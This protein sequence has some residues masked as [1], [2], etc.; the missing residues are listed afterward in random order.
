[1]RGMLSRTVTFAAT[2]LFVTGARAQPSEVGRWQD[3]GPYGG[4]VVAIARSPVMPD[5][6]F[7][8]TDGFAEYGGLFRSTDGGTTWFHAS[9]LEDTPIRAL[10]FTPDGTAFAGTA[11]DSLWRSADGGLEWTVLNLGVSDRVRTV[12]THPVDNSRIWASVGSTAAWLLHSDDGGDTWQDVGIPTNNSFMGCAAIA[13]DAADPD[14]AFAACGSPGQLWFSSDGGLSW[15]ERTAGLPSMT[16][17][18]LAHD[19]TR[20]LVGGTSGLYASSD[21]GLSWVRLSF[22]DARAVGVDPMEPDV[23]YLGSDTPTGLHRSTD[24]GMS[25]QLGVPGTE[26]LTINALELAPGD[27]SRV[28]LGANALGISQSIDSGTSFQRTSRGMTSMKITAA[29]VNPLDSSNLAASFESLNEGGVFLSTD[30]GASWVLDEDLPGGRIW[31]VAFSPQGVLHAI[32]RGSSSVPVP[33]GVYRRGIDG[34]WESLGPT[35]EDINGTVLTVL[36]F[37]ELDPNLLVVGGQDFFDGGNA[38]SIWLSQDAGASWSNAYRGTLGQELVRE[39]EILDNGTTKDM[40][41]VSDITTSNLSGQALRSTDGGMSWF[42]SNT[43]L[44]ADFKGR[45]ICTATGEPESLFVA[46]RDSVLPPQTGALF[47]STDSGTS[48]T[49]T[50][51]EGTFMDL[52]CGPDDAS[53]LYGAFAEDDL[54]RLSVDRGQTFSAFDEGL[55]R[56]GRGVLSSRGDGLRLVHNLDSRPQLYLSSSTGVWVADLESD[57]FADGFESGDLSAW[58]RTQL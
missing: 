8:G 30:R 48:W 6:I 27:P 5:L 4:S 47:E 17:F 51:F 9:G 42:P 44:P 7:A 52:V 15:I 38:A 25:W 43:G 12:A 58:T 13:F 53:V 55:E 57:I 31:Y 19:G 22:S 50:G 56:A 37:S 18:D 1:M 36:R 10:A 46:H 33:L 23:L 3:I 29:A 39:I 26:G 49:P 21:D 16:F 54:V 28:W 34:T 20:I 35:A 2:V 40:L 45:A 41:A 14:N 11:G 32:H 24:G